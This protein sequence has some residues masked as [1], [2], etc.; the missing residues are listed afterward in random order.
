MDLENNILFWQKLDTLYL[1]SSLVYTRRKGD[2]HPDYPNLV[3]PVD[4]AY[5]KDSKG[6]D[7]DKIKAFIGTEKSD[8]LINYIIV[9][10][11]ILN[12]DLVVK[13]LVNCSKEEIKQVLLFQNQTDF[14]KTILVHRGGNQPYWAAESD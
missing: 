6:T 9:S 11:D 10:V 2:K 1:S 3:Y 13:L 7:G 5:L 8:N 12:R 14:Q 4:Y